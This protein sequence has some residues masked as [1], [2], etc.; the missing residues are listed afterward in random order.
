MVASLQDWAEYY[1]KV[2]NKSRGG[3]D[4]Y[5]FQ[6]KI[7][8]FKTMGERKKLIIF[9]CLIAVIV[10]M[11]IFVAYGIRDKVKQV[12]EQ[13]VVNQEKEVMKLN[14]LD[15]GQGDATLIDFPNGEQMLIDCAKDTV[16]IE[17]LG[18]AMSVFDRK[19]DYLLI[20]NPDLDHYGGCIDVLRRFE[21]KHIIHNGFQKKDTMWQAFLSEAQREVASG[22]NILIATTTK[23]WF[24]GSAQ[25]SLLYPDHDITLDPKVP[26]STEK[27]SVNNTSI[28]TKI[29]YGTQDI[30]F[31]GDAEVAEEKYLVKKYGDALDVEVVK[32]AHHCS[33]SSSIQ[34]F[35]TKTTPAHAVCS[36]GKNNAYRHPHRRVLRRVERAG[37][38]IWRTDL[39]GDILMTVTNDAIEV[40]P[41]RSQ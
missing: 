1:T 9:G 4:K 7:L 6:F 33:Q 13:Q 12:P 36:S 29:S 30:I 27:I 32:L 16:V 19:I 23:D 40:K 37:A 26:S 39:N 10:A 8:K 3:G 25:I 22:A 11:S 34:E 18:R 14:F 20:T 5:N 28:V 24:I 15:I 17:A 2:G 38:K 21:V 41:A 35:I 31:P